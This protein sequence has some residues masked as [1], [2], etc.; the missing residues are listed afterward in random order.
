VNVFSQVFFAQA[1]V[2]APIAKIMKSQLRGE[3]W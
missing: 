1:T 2:S 3:H